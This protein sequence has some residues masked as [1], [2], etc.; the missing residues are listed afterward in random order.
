M[1][2]YV[3]VKEGGR[4]WQGGPCATYNEAATIGIT[5]G[6]E[7]EVCEYNTRDPRKAKAIHNMEL[8]KTGKP[9]EDISKRH[10]KIKR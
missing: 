6:Q 5:R 3:F 10:Y 2:F 8:F 9:I 4:I 7:Y 1:P